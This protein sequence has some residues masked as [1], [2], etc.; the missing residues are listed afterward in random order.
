MFDLVAKKIIIESEVWVATD[1]FVAPGVRIGHGSV[2]GAR[3]SVFSDIP[4]GVIAMGTPARVV[5]QRRVRDSL[6]AN[7][8]E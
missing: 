1:V 4:P 6:Q 8:F 7:S 2:I 5:G 3:S